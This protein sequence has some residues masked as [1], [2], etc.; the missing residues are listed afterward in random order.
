[1][2]GEGV[3]R[4]WMME[5]EERRRGARVQF[6]TDFFAGQKRRGAWTRP[7]LRN[8]VNSMNYEYL[9]RSIHEKSR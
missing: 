3:K 5:L 2:D 1:M 9:L 8:W 4:W 7:T 6:G